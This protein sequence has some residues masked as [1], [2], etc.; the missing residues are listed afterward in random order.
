MKLYQIGTVYQGKEGIMRIEIYSQYAKGLD[1]IEKL[2]KIYV[3]YWMHQLSEEDRKTLRVHPQGNR[4][5]PLTGVFAVRS[6][7]RPNPIGLSCVELV[8]REGNNLF[9]KGLDAF[10]KSPIIDIKS[11]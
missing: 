8:R 9:I 4:A 6:P 11:G 1:R 10:N 3:L 2:K 7:M 5:K